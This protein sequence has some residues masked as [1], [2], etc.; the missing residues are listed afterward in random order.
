MHLDLS[1][2]AGS[3]YSS[4]INNRLITL[5]P[6]P[7]GDKQRANQVRQ[8]IT[9]ELQQFGTPYNQAQF[10]L[11][12]SLNKDT[13][14]TSR[15][16]IDVIVSLPVNLSNYPPNE[17][18]RQTLLDEIADFYKVEPPSNPD[19]LN[20]IIF[21]SGYKVDLLPS[22]EINVNSFL[23]LPFRQKQPYRGYIS[24]EHVSFI[25]N[26]GQ[27]FQ[28]FCRFVK[29]WAHGPSEQDREKNSS[30]FFL[31]LVAAE[32]HDR[33]PNWKMLQLTEA[34]FRRMK[35]LLR[36]RKGRCKFI[37]FN[38]YYSWINYRQNWINDLA[39]LDPVNP[40][41]NIYKKNPQ[42]EHIG[43]L[44]TRARESLKLWQDKSFGE[45]F[46]NYFSRDPL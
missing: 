31:E 23:Q 7:I 15:R 26:R 44:V 6:D 46:K 11:A 4:L 33:N 2:K 37:G 12:G 24:L 30:S 1:R 43:N 5:R 19:N 28:E 38:D 14:L 45:V 25:Q 27:K 40:E 21:K 20:V 22:F 10:K 41:D 35:N 36:K 16:E 29:Y 17:S 13:M 9:K 39:V 34:F 42:N 18:S 32:I 8:A 3:S